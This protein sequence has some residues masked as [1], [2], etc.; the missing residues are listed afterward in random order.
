[1]MWWTLEDD[2]LKPDLMKNDP[3]PQACL[4]MISCQCHTG[5]KYN[6]GWL[7]CTDSC[8]CVKSIIS[9]CMNARQ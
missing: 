4:E 3:I 7:P 2:Q 5:C 8:I 6:K 9:S 1:M